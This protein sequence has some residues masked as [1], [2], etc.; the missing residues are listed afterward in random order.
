[1]LVGGAGVEPHI[2]GVT[3]LFVVGSIVAEQLGRIEL[4]PG[5]DAF[6]LDALGDGLHQLDG[7]RMQ[8]TAFLVQEEGDRH[9]PVALAR[10]APVRPVGDHRV[11]PRLAPAGVELGGLDRTQCAL[12]QGGAVS[13]GLV[14]AD[15]P[16]R[17]RPIDE[18][19]LVAPAVHVAVDD[20]VVRQQRADLGELVDDRRVRLPDVH[21]A[22]E[23]QVG[24]VLPAAHH[25]RQ[26]LL[27]AAAIGMPCAEVLDAMR[28]RGVHDAGAGVD[29]DVIGEVDR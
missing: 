26:D 21:A 25:Q 22:E 3:D 29:A 10:D 27:V 5:L 20:L 1:M 17:R 8:L 4:E 14:H 7:A 18:R 12:A 2:E 24:H 13:R 15:E 19:G 16:L 9:T 6:T 28:G 23:G 11:Q